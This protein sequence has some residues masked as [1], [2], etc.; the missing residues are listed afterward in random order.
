[1]NFNELIRHHHYPELTDKAS[2]SQASS[3]YTSLRVGIL[4]LCSSAGY[5]TTLFVLRCRLPHG[6]CEEGGL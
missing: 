1:M 2:G 6:D 5:H 4:Y 3:S